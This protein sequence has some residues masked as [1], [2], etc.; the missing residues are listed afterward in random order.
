MF[1]ESRYDSY[2]GAQKS[3][4]T[5]INSLDRNQFN[6]NIVTTEDG[7]FLKGFEQESDF[8]VDVVKLGKKANVFGGEVFNYSIFEKMLVAIQLFIYNFKILS[9][10]HR[11]KIDIIYV[12]DLR[13]L[14]YSVI[15]SKIL[16]KKVIWYIRTEVDDS[17]LTYFGLKNADII[18]TIAQGVLKNLPK[19]KIGKYNNKITNVYTGFDFEKFSIK[20]KEIAKKELS[21]SNEKFII[22][23]LGSI[24]SRKG[25]DILVDAY[26]N[27]LSKYDNIELLIVGDV[28]NG[29]EKYWNELKLKLKEANAKYIYY[30]YSQNV[31]LIYSALDVFVL[32]SRSEGLPR[33]VIEALA[34]N[35][36]VVSTNVG[37]A[38]EIIN[39]NINGL[40][41]EKD[42]TIELF[43]AIELLITNPNVRMELIKNASDIK[44]IF[45]LTTYKRKINILFENVY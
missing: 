34:H 45:S 24:N 17:K 40:L 8:K 28:S 26:I 23:Y 38:G 25:L 36:P 44:S 39:N 3:M 37:G 6:F 18:I 41:I 35:L 21:L 9:Y 1:L 19:S 7:E 27:L 22:G 15:A 16:R 13:A 33:V 42:S 43:N 12:N 11:K 4:L 20:D 30:S 5:L 29:Y 14:I 2:Y 32:P 10:V 31:S